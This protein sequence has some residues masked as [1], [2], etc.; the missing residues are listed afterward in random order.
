M[1]PTVRRRQQERGYV[2]IMMTALAV[3]L[4]AAVGLA[5]DMGRLMI[6]KAETQAYVDSAA[7]AA[8]RELDGTTT[9]ITAAQAAV[10]GSGNSWNMNTQSVNT[11]VVS[12]ATSSAGPWLTNPNPATGYIYARVQLSTTPRLYFAPSIF[13]RYTANALPSSRY[14]QTVASRATAGQIAITT[15]TQG[16]SPYTAVSTNPVGP[17][18]GLTVGASYTIQWPPQNGGPGCG[19]NNPDKC[20]VKNPCA[21]D[22]NAAKWAVYSNWGSQTNG[23]WGF[24]SNSEIR[25][26]VLDGLQTQPISVGDNIA[27]GGLGLL[28]NGNKAAQADYLDERAQQDGYNG[29]NNV[30]SY[31]TNVN[32]NGR[33]LMLVPIVNPV[34]A[35]TSTVLGWG[36]VLLYSNGNSTNYYDHE[37]NGNDPFCG[38]YA[39]PYTVGSEDPGGAVNGT[40]AYRVKLVE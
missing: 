19:E 22:S 33:R 3:V 32:R 2:L 29:T 6:T 26:S 8:A 37:A 20:Y 25:Q 36:L 1:K 17:N 28:S 40:G 30:A 24:S 13:L 10:S 15:F 14:L 31:L 18:F 39:G 12:F 7:L 21:G 11:A 5:I 4:L 34:N 23:Y 38:M 16:A 27:S 9:G 35:T